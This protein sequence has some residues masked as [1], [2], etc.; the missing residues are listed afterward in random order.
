[1]GVI[2]GLTIGA[3]GAALSGGL[4]IDQ[5]LNK[6]SA[7]KV[8]SGPQPI[9]PTQANQ[10]KAAVSQ[11]APDIVA[12]TGG[13]VSPA[14]TMALSAL[15]AGTA[16]TPG[17]GGAAQSVI[18]QLFGT[19][20]ATTAGVPSLAAGGGASAGSGVADFKPAGVGG[21][22]NSFVDEGLSDLSRQF[23]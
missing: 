22:S 18:D 3:I 19:S 8:P 21:G 7:P 16:G 20:G 17:A 23:A 6:P 1:M 5:L 10:V 9:N 13:S 15:Q 14:Y 2:A 4:G 12:Q 11:Q